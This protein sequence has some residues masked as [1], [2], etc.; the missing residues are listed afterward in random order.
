ME[1]EGGEPEGLLWFGHDVCY[2]TPL[3][4]NF[5]INACSNHFS[6]S[7]DTEGWNTI[8]ILEAMA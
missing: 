5:P 4:I 3:L 6:L 2:T 8:A 7:F 1:G